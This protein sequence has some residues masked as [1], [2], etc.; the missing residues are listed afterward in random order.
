MRNVTKNSEFNVLINPDQMNKKNKVS[1]ISGRQ[2]II[3]NLDG[4]WNLHNDVFAVH[5]VFIDPICM[6]L[7]STSIQRRLEEKD[8]IRSCVECCDKKTSPVADIRIVPREIRIV[9]H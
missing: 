9:Q 2:P 8:K 6:R 4:P 3:W 1:C 7:T 5:P